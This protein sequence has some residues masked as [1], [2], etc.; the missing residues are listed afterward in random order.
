MS[1]YRLPTRCQLPKT[2][3]AAKENNK[4]KKKKKKKKKENPA[5]YEDSSE[6]TCPYPLLKF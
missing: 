5:P 3:P 1:P 4:K 2:L 6:L